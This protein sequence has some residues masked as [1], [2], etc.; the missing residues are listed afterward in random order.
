MCIGVI[1]A[2]PGVDGLHAVDLL[3]PLELPVKQDLLVVDILELTQQSLVHCV[4]PLIRHQEAVLVVLQ[5]VDAIIDK[6][7]EVLVVGIQVGLGRSELLNDNFGNQLALHPLHYLS[8]IHLLDL[9]DLVLALLDLTL[10]LVIGILKLDD[11]TLH[12]VE[13]IG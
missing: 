5:L 8:R 4:K 10:T 2:V 3:H 7:P 13:F 6:T 1:E 11:I 9:L 12:G